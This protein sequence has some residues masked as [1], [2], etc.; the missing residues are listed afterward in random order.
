MIAVMPMLKR[1]GLLIRR[2]MSEPGSERRFCA[3]STA[4]Y[5][6]RKQAKAVHSQ[7]MWPASAAAEAGRSLRQP[8][9]WSGAERSL[10]RASWPKAELPCFFTERR[11][12][13]SCRRQERSRSIRGCSGT[14]RG[15]GRAAS[16]A[17]RRGARG[18]GPA[19]P[20]GARTA[21]SPLSQMQRSGAKGGG[22]PADD[23]Q[24]AA[25]ATCQLAAAARR[26]QARRRAR[27]AQDAGVH[28]RPRLRPANGCSAAR[29]RGRRA[30]VEGLGVQPPHSGQAARG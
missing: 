21:P 12:G 13:W 28:L 6:R 3:Q 20:V 15:G 18:G 30:V 1:S 9:A 5:L 29:V 22:L 16:A 2:R 27:S 8:V 25:R 24:A 4:A 11:T 19:L 23:P 17:R 7:E 10:P 26:S 14:E